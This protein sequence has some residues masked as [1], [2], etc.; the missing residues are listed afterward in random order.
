MRKARTNPNGANQY[1]VDPR[2]ALFLEYYL[3]PKAGTFSNALQSAL[4][5]GFTQSYAESLMAQ[6]PEWLSEKLGE[7]NMLSKAERN[8]NK[9]LDLET[10]VIAGRH[11]DRI[12]RIKADI[13]KFVAE[14]LGKTKYGGATNTVNIQINSVSGMSNEQLEAILKERNESTN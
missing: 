3:D 1:V 13:S 14:R 4:K 8:L 10:E 9:M 12:L 2:Q 7:L 6:L 5:A 11:D